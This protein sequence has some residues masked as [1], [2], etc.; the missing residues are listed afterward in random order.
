MKIK[1]VP[2]YKVELSLYDLGSR[3]TY[4]KHEFNKSLYLKLSP[5]FVG[6]SGKDGD[7]GEAGPKGET[8]TGNFLSI[9]D[10]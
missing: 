10:W 8:G 4:D 6:E 2:S 9:V 7:D 5:F 1:L 3:E